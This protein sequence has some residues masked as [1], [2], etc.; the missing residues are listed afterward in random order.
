M[1][2]LR[3]C[4]LMSQGLETPSCSTFPQPS[5]CTGR[6]SCSVSPAG[7]ST[8][9]SSTSTLICRPPSVSSPFWGPGSGDISSS[10]SS[11]SVSSSL[12]WAL[13]T[14][15]G[16]VFH[17]SKQI[18]PSSQ[19][20]SSQPLTILHPKEF[21]KLTQQQLPGPSASEQPFQWAATEKRDQWVVIQSLPS[22]YPTSTF[23]L[24]IV[25]PK[26]QM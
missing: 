21:P 3:N 1:E 19:F 10:S 16:T 9:G 4:F 24:C 14:G 12:H 23:Y 18:P 26:Y 25:F 17:R 5:P 11:S 7:D 13:E 6:I 20:P 22:H 8:K 2:L 15:P